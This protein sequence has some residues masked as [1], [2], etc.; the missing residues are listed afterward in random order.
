MRRWEYT[1]RLIWWKGGILSSAYELK[2]G[3][4]TLKDQEVWNH[5]DDLGREGW[6]LVSVTPEIKGHGASGSSTDG[7]MMWFKR[8]IDDDT[9]T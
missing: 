5:I 3:G 4:R 7:Y 6:E 9:R 1:R 8:P 2:T